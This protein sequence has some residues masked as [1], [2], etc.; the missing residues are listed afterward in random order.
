MKLPVID[1]NLLKN[2]DDAQWAEFHH[3]MPHL[4]IV[5]QMAL[6]KEQDE[7]KAPRPADDVVVTCDLCANTQWWQD[8]FG[9][10]WQAAQWFYCGPLGLG[11]SNIG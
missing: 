4:H 3:F 1:F 5:L 8:N 11:C 6:V 2:F 9:S 7:E 10:V